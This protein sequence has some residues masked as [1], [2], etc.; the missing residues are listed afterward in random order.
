MG[1]IVKKFLAKKWGV[2]SVQQ[3]A[4]ASGPSF[5]DLLFLAA[6]SCSP[7]SIFHVCIMPCYDKK[8]EGSREEFFDQEH[9]TRDVSFV[10]ASGHVLLLSRLAAGGRAHLRL[11][12]RLSS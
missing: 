4:V 9:K 8:L 2:R 5:T 7:A 10:L 6:T 12:C 11:L 1:T 3:T